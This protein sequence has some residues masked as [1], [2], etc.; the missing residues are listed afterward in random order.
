MIIRGILSVDA[1]LL[2]QGSSVNADLIDQSEASG[3]LTTRSGIDPYCDLTADGV[4]LLDT[5]DKQIRA[6]L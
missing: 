5:D 2:G 4:H 3:K 6:L 1:N